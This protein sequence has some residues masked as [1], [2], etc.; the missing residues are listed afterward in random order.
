MLVFPH[1]PHSDGPLLGSETPSPCAAARKWAVTELTSLV[2]LS[3]GPLS[4][5]ACLPVFENH[6]FIYFV[7]SFL[8]EGGRAHL[9]CVTDCR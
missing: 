3:Q 7:Q 2:L 4:C 6:C 9:V 1:L 8:V 5:A